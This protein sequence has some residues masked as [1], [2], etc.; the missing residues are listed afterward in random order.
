[1]TQE[2]KESIAKMIAEVTAHIAEMRA[3]LALEEAMPL[4]DD[5][6]YVVA[7]N[8]DSPLFFRP[9]AGRFQVGGALWCEKFTRSEALEW[10]RSGLVNG[11]G[12][13]AFA[14]P[15]RTALK[16]CIGLSLDMI[17]TLEAVGEA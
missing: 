2:Q 6:P 9:S 14:L 16:Q 8:S 7:F 12:E 4:T 17:G 11:A 5:R 1:M 13:H 10:V 3:A 15:Y